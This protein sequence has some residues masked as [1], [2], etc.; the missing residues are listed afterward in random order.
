MRRTGGFAGR[1]RSRT[2]ALAELPDPDTAAWRELLAT[3]RLQALAAAVER[4][5]PDAYCYGVRCAVPEVDVVVPEPA[6]TDDVRDLLERTLRGG[7]ARLSRRGAR[8]AGRR[9]RCRAV[10]AGIVPSDRLVRRRG[11]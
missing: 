9:A 2:V 8:A 6:L 5:Y 1:T 10:G 4:E 11:E 3:D 7:D